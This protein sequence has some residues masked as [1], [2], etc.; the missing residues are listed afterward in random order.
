METDDLPHPSDSPASSPA[1]RPTSPI[2]T[3]PAQPGRMEPGTS[4]SQGD[5]KKNDQLTTG[6]IVLIVVLLFI[7]L[8]LS[9]NGSVFNSGADNGDL[10][11][12]EAQNTK[13]LAEVNAERA[14]LGLAPMPAGVDSARTTAARL[15]RDANSL[16]ALIAQWERELETKDAAIGELQGQ[17]ASRDENAKHLYSQI[18]SLQNQLDLSA[19]AA[20]QLA[21]L[22]SDLEMANN[23]IEGYRKELAELQGRPT[24]EEAA[25]L[26]K[27]LNE[28][29]ENTGKLKMQID[30]LLEA[31]NDKAGNKLYNEALQEIENLRASNHSMRYDL[32]SLRAELD[33]GNLFVESENELPAAAARLFARLR[34]L[35]DANKQQ[36]E[37]AYENFRQSINAEIIHRQTFASGS[38]QITFDREK[39]IQDILDKRKDHNAFFLVVGYASTSGD[40]EA[41]RKLSARRATTVASIVNTLKASDQQVKAV[42]LGETRR[43]S[44]KAEMDNQICEIWEIKL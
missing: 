7:M 20:S 28:S 36:L 26:R 24:Q 3:S 38:S 6:L 14:R 2:G 44:P 29:L 41:N 8:M 21:S 10:T 17:I 16:S 9:I 27:E 33:R 4:A 34:T 40:T 25:T 18:A 1:A 22:G 23:Q 13:L 42:Y 12:L 32:Q 31:S 35:E 30:A 15:Q 19:N 11:S 37:A 5:K 43:F 39:I